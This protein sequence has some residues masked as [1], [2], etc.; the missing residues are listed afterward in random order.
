MDG[1]YSGAYLMA[2]A[3]GEVLPWRGRGAA[4]SRA[5][6]ERG[7]STGEAGQVP[8]DAEGCPGIAGLNS[9]TGQRKDTRTLLP[10]PQAGWEML[11]SPQYRHPGD[12]SELRITST[13]PQPAHPLPVLI[14]ADTAG[15]SGCS[16][17]IPFSG[18]SPDG[19]GLSVLFP[20]QALLA[21][22]NG[23][24]LSARAVCI[25]SPEKASKS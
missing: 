2:G 5:M 16:R 15:P 13:L 1:G 6:G 21:G 11:P 20:L 8:V 19:S 22:R 24:V 10:L 14:G 12:Q 18:S 9:S 23:I 3:Q 17:A 7:A 25:A 4:P